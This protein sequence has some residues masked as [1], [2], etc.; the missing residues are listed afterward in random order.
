M[1]L[2]SNFALVAQAAAADAP[3][4]LAITTP[5]PVVKPSV[6]PPAANAAALKKAPVA[7]GAFARAAYPGRGLPKVTRAPDGRFVATGRTGA[8]AAVAAGSRIIPKYT[9]VMNYTGARPAPLPEDFRGNG[10][11]LVKVDGK[12]NWGQIFGAT[13]AKHLDGSEIKE[14]VLITRKGTQLLYVPY[15]YYR[16][17][18]AAQQ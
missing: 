8:A 7:E 18:S 11:M 6:V 15:E 3:H 1:T 17:A 16:K 12:G 5:R 2:V 9:R 4:A 14:P 13:P 10:G